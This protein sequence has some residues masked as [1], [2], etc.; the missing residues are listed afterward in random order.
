L[1]GL[2]ALVYNFNAAA[3]KRLSVLVMRVTSFV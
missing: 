2:K 3:E 1:T